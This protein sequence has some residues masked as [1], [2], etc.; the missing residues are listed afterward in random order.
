MHEK[1]INFL[2]YQTV[3]AKKTIQL[4]QLQKQLEQKEQEAE[5]NGMKR[6][7]LRDKVTEEEIARIIERL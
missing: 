4:P 3:F 7:L 5:E 1:L 6:S 2:P